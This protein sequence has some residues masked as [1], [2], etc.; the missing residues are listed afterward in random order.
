MKSPFDSSHVFNNADSFAQA[1]D[2]AW[3]AHEQSNPSHGLTTAEKLTLI[4]DQLQDH[5]FL[6]TEPDRARQV[7]SFRIRLLN[8]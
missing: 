1:F 3:Q 2:Q 5:P 7:A 8:F 6:I 4:F